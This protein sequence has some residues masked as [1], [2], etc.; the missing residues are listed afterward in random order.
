MATCSFP[1]AAASSRNARCPLCNRSKQP[2]TM[3]RGTWGMSPAARSTEG[4]DVKRCGGAD[5]STAEQ[6]VTVGA[7]SSE[8]ANVKKLGFIPAP[9]MGD[10]TDYPMESIE[11]ELKA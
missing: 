8:I 11:G 5:Q 2:L 4:T 7:A 6:P 10:S 1:S 3:T 9:H